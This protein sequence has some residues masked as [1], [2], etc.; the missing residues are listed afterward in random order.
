MEFSLRE[1]NKSK[2]KNYQVHNKIAKDNVIKTT[3]KLFFVYPFVSLKQIYKKVKSNHEMIC[4]CSSSDNEAKD[5]LSHA[6]RYNLSDFTRS[7]KD[8]YN[9]A[10]KYVDAFAKDI[11][12]DSL[13]LCAPYFYE[14]GILNS[15]IYTD[16]ENNK[17]I[18]TSNCQIMMD[19]E[20]K[21][22]QECISLLQPY[23]HVL[24]CGYGLGHSSMSILKQTIDEYTLIESDINLYNTACHA[25]KDKRIKINIIC[26]EWFKNLKNMKKNSIDCVFIDDTP[27]TDF[28]Y[29]EYYVNS[30]NFNTYNPKIVLKALY[31]VL[32]DRF[33]ISFYCYG[34]REC[35]KEYLES[36]N[37]KELSLDV[38]QTCHVN[39]SSH[40]RYIDNQN[41][42][43][44]IVVYEGHKCE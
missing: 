5:I 35:V 12:E 1:N 22:M 36:N 40:C 25:C 6:L 7:Q 33:R 29:G 41:G 17:C 8:E 20:E 24:E 14:S 15:F 26:G 4:I 3:S 21:Y 28:Y 23:G 43:F 37:S 31:P 27:S 38:F 32:K 34:D 16:N 11:I 19:F 18:M 10:L 42:D 2:L 13:K 44:F 9:Q 30:P 39:I